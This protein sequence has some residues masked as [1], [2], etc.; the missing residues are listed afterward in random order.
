MR[1]PRLLL[2]AALAALCVTL[3]F[4]ADNEPTQ[5]RVNAAV[6]QEPHSVDNN[7]VLAPQMFIPPHSWQKAQLP[8]GEQ[9]E[10]MDNLCYNIHS[11]VVAEDD[12]TGVTHRVSES[13]CTRASR[14]QMKSADLP[15]K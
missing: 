4:A 13:T 10:S 11:V 5:P 12:H 2:L 1:L 8:A 14:F 7:A 9:P 6:V 3:S 15:A